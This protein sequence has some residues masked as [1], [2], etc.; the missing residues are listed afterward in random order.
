MKK[1]W[2][3]LAAVMISAAMM[4]SAAAC[5]NQV[6][7]NSNPA[8]AGGDTGEKQKM[9]LWHIWPEGNGG[10]ADSFAKTLEE[11]KAKFPDIDLQVDAIS[12]SGDSYKTK[13]KA[14]VAA[15]QAPDI[16]FTWGGGWSQNFID[17]GKVLCLDDYVDQTVLDKLIPGTTNYF[18]YDDK[19]YALPSR[20]NVAMLFCNTELF[21]KVGVDYP[22]TMDDLY[23]AVEKFRAAGYTPLA[24]GGKDKW[25]IGIYL[26]GIATRTAGTSYVN[27][28]LAGKKS[29]DTPEIAQSVEILQHLVDI[30]GFDKGVMAINRD[31]SQVPFLEG[32]IPMYIQGSFVVSNI[33][34]SPIG[35]KVKAINIPLVK[36]G[37]GTAT[38]F[39]GGA[40]QTF[41]INKKTADPQKAVELYTYMCETFSKEVYLSGGGLPTWKVDYDTSGISNKIIV[42][43]AN[44][45]EKSTGMTLW[46]NTVLT[47][48][49]SQIHEDLCVQAMM[50]EITPEE[51]CKQSEKMVR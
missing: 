48:E 23:A 12:D 31:E 10:T 37:K 25:P 20:I 42:D 30:G 45:F 39:L 5:S 14:A 4:V 17:A 49:N 9:T 33:A 8:S 1:G 3:R 28:A 51:F 15:D 27:D 44:Q 24:C 22:E 7:S 6:T 29:L 38:E 46:W 21:Q 32:Q 19:L 41:M 16:F 35:D 43:I 26:N 50:K 18:T 34:E 13:L 36:G 11:T 40:D 2:K 47:G